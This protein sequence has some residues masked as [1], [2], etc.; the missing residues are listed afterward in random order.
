[1]RQVST[2]VFMHVKLLYTHLYITP[3]KRSN[4]SQC[5]L[6]ISPLKITVFLETKKSCKLAYIQA[7]VDA[8]IGHAYLI[9]NAAFY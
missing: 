2:N 1:M 4:N 7:P 8:D 6:A 9:F 3:K 5:F